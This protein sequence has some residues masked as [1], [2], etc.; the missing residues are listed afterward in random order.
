[1][2]FSLR[3]GDGSTR[4]G[5]AE[6]RRRIVDVRAGNV[7]EHPLNRGVIMKEHRSAGRPEKPKGDLA[8]FA[9]MIFEVA[10]NAITIVQCGGYY[11]DR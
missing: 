2:G 4:E 10:E 7:E 8:G 9:G 1:M 6:L 3:D 5:A 11:G